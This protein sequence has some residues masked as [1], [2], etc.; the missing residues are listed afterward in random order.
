MLYASTTRRLRPSQCGRLTRP[1]SC[2]EI[3]SAESTLNAGLIF[4]LNYLCSKNT[5]LYSGFC[6]WVIL[7]LFL[8]VFGVFKQTIQFYSKLMRKCPSSIP[9]R[10]LN[11][12][13]SDYESPPLTTRPPCSG[14]SGKQ[15]YVIFLCSCFFILADIKMHLGPGL[16]I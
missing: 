5:K 9:R 14:L 2:S 12:P 10:N 15:E 6:K 13:P 16:Y 8:F 11:L 3:K 7:S 4:Y 1:S